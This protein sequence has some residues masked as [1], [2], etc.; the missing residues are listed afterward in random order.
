MRPEQR[1]HDR[2]IP[3]EN[4]FAAIGPKYTKVGKIKDICLGGLAFEYIEMEGY[5]NEG[6]NIDIFL[7]GIE[8]HLYKVPCEVIYNI[9]VSAP[10]MNNKFNRL[11]SAKRCGVKFEELTRDLKALLKFFLQF[12]V[13]GKIH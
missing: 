1:K 12:H 5:N 7:V 8:F 9:D 4:A 3:K 13:T 10:Y 11:F 6:S 2:F